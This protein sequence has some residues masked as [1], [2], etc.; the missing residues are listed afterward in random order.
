MK[1]R[2]ALMRFAEA[3][4]RTLQANDHKDGWDRCSPGWLLGRAGKELKEARLAYRRW[5]EFRDF[6]NVAEDEKR[7]LDLQ[8]EMTDVANFC[9]MVFDVMEETKLCKASLNSAE[10]SK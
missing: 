9:M 2:P 10:G 8:A 5:V 3:M 4:E 7:L 1:V 6:K